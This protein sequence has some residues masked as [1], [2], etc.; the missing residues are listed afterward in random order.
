[1]GSCARRVV[2]GLALMLMLSPG[3][4]EARFETPHTARTVLER[5]N[6]ERRSAGIPG[7]RY[8]RDLSV[9]AA[10]FSRRQLAT[11]RFG[12]ERSIRAPG[13][14]R[15]LGE[16]LALQRGWRLRAGAVVNG[17]ERSS[18]HR[19]VVGSAAF[20]YVG[21]GWAQGRLGGRPITIWTAQLGG[22]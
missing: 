2:S 18:T 7:L 15:R 5:L 8:S 6:H 20:G 19:S 4:A 10:R 14:F 1:M 21:I 12:H 9:S 11:G 3:I 22:R 16:V 13:S 17:W